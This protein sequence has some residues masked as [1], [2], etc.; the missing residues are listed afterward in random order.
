MGA[1]DA[2]DFGGRATVPL[3]FGATKLP[4]GRGN[5]PVGLGTLADGALADGALA[6]AESTP[7]GELAGGATDGVAVSIAG[8]LAV[9]V[10]VTG[11]VPLAAGGP[12]SES[13]VRSS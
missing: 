1:A 8:A 6:D 13:F 11:R 2:L 3:G 4:V 7:A 10:A 5:F 9:A 12:G